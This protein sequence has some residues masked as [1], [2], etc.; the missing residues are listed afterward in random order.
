[1]D[2]ATKA[3]SLVA[4]SKGMPDD[5]GL[6]QGSRLLGQRGECFLAKRGRLWPGDSGIEPTGVDDQGRLS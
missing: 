1:M 2:M 5:D 6:E 4:V 3:R